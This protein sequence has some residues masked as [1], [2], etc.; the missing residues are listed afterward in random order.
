[1]QLL[2]S[3]GGGTTGSDWQTVRRSSRLVT[4][5]HQLDHGHQTHDAP[6]SEL[7][8][9][10]SLQRY[11]SSQKIENNLSPPARL[12]STE[13]RCANVDPSGRRATRARHDPSSNCL[14]FT[15]CVDQDIDVMV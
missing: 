2:V 9:A 12:D 4:V 15:Q 6:L 11:L 10:S 1:M 14:V 7:L 3:G 8:V 13:F 5:F